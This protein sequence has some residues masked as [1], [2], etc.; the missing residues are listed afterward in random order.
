MSERAPATSEGRQRALLALV[1]GGALSL[2]Y[3]ARLLTVPRGPGE[4]GYAPFGPEPLPYAAM[5]GFTYEQLWGH[6]WRAG[7]LAP[8]LL[9]M[10]LGLAR[11]RP[12]T[13]RT[14]SRRL[15]LAA[16]AFS[17]AV[18]AWVML[19]VLR[20]RAIA[21]D[22]LVYHMQATFYGALHLTGPDIGLTP[23]DFFTIAT[24]AGYT[25]KYLP[26]EGLVQVL[27]VFA[28]IPALMHLPLLGLTL[29][30]WH[31]QVTLRH[32]PRLADFATVALALS[33]MVMLTAATGLSETT[34]LC[35]VALAGLGLEWARGTRPIAGGVLAAA[36][37]SFGFAT[38]PQSLLPVGAL[39]GPAV[40]WT[41]LRGRRFGALVAFA[42]VLALGAGLVGLYDVALSGSPLTLPWY[43][44]CTIEHYGFGRV[45]KYD[46]FEHTPI[47]ALQNLGVV[48]V[49]LNAWWLGLPCSLFVLGLAAW[50]RVRLAPFRLWLGVAGA[51][52]LFELAYYSP[53]ASDTGSIYHHELVLPGSLVVAAV[54]E[55]LLE[56]AF[57]LTISGMLVHVALGTVTFIAE[58]TLRIERLVAAIHR[59]SDAALAKIDGPAL[60]FHEL[61]GSEVRVVG[62]VFDSFPKRNRGLSDRVVTFP[63]L[64]RDK[65]ER[66]ARTYPGRACFYY[67]RNPDTEAA[68]LHRCEEARELMDRPYGRDDQRPLW[69]PSTAYQLTNFDPFHANANRHVRDAQ[70]HVVLSCCALRDFSALGASIPPELVAHCVPDGP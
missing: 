55:T 60:L 53:G 15:A 62:W 11:L 26:G 56:R 6:V 22:E 57:A 39:L 59:D 44:Q 40:A 12:V 52:V 70:G 17:L 54:L 24:R 16:A 42:L 5:R 18:T 63:E 8:G 43:L 36:A 69:I 31:R 37:L 13:F 50:L 67:R 7:L 58:Q 9:L 32:G 61:R 64:P 47:T 10:S 65:R 41:L 27:G 34:S 38:R 46:T 14:T 30:A 4:F 28:G 45:W 3:F 68:E 23:P 33:P 35:M 20:G 48:L 66:I 49:R 25:G 1:L 2:A 19:G 29:L 51:V 21:D